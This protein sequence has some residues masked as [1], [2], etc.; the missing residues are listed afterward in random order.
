MLYADTF[1][2]RFG[3]FVFF[4]VFGLGANCYL[5]IQASDSVTVHNLTYVDIVGMNGTVLLRLPLSP[6]P[7]APGTFTAANFTPPAEYFHLGVSNF[8]DPR[9]ETRESLPE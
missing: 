1:N 4:S 6:L 8:G 3:N 7:S 2:K 5:L 9:A